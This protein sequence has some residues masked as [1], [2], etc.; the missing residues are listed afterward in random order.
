VART[1]AL[2]LMHLPIRAPELIS[3]RLMPR[4]GDLFAA[5]RLPRSLT[6]CA[7]QF[8]LRDFIITGSRRRELAA[9]L[10]CR[11]DDCNDV[12]GILMHTMDDNIR[13]TWHSKDPGPRNNT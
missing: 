3:V 2:T 5:A 11:V 9:P 8:S 7:S 6:A 13:Q 1:A 4:P 12:H 10:P